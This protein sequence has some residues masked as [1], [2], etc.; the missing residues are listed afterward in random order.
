MR[1]KIQ[2]ELL[3]INILSVVLILTISFF[4]IQAL[5]IILGLPF[6]LFF[7][8]YTLIAALF[9]KKSGLDA[10]ERVAL[11]FG[12]SI[13][14]VPLIGLVLNYT[15]WG[16]RLYP[17]LVSLTVFI[18]AMSAI[19]WYRRHGLPEQEKLNLIL[20]LSLP[21][22]ESRLD[23]A[24]SIVLILAIVGAIGTLGYVIASPRVGERFTEFYILGLEGKA[25]GYPT[26][27]T[28]GEEGRVI[29]GITNREHE[30]M[31]Y[32]VKIKVDGVLQRRIGPVEL[33]HEESWREQV[34][35]VPQEPGEDQKV[36]FVLYKIRTLG[37]EDEPSLTLHLWI[38]V[39]EGD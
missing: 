12:L 33:E 37:T 15:P 31:G 14:V 30:I 35:F 39:K 17:I 3:A 4:P 29:L 24:L 9:P 38:D 13:A 28:V 26:E 23:R 25:E 32:E 10:I 2:N 22:Q 7:P 20:N 11:S 34:G 18:A 6:I 19:A 1:I 8:G 21:R 16:I 5:R 27:L 36:Q